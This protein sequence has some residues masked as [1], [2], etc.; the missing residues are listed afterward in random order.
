[1]SNLRVYRNPIVTLGVSLCLGLASS[2]AQ[3]VT[4]N[5]A[6]PGFTATTADG[7][8][9]SLE[10]LRGKTV[11]LEWSNHQCPFV[12]KH[13]DKS[14]N[15]PTLQKDAAADGVVWVQVLSSAPGKQGHVDGATALELN[16]QRGAVPSYVVLD[17][18]G[19]IGKL[20]E[21]QTTPHLY[22]IDKSGTLV[23]KGGIDSIQS[24]KAEDISKATPYVR[25]A[26]NAIKAGNAVPTAVTQPYGCSVKYAG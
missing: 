21:A 5:Q 20:Y 9:L 8:T 17:P 25:D 23:Y 1:M 4:I 18:T 10:S 3:A 16:K 7:K 24:N 15:I 19:S 13:Y 11:V 6:A 14:H 12:K 2:V 22:I 26:L